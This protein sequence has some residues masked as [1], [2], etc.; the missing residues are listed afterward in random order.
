MARNDRIE[1]LDKLADAMLEAAK[2]VDYDSA[3]ED[4]LFDLD[5]VLRH[6]EALWGVA[7]HVIEVD[8]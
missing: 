4:L 7:P 6:Y 3:M 2:R 8:A 5:G 1:A